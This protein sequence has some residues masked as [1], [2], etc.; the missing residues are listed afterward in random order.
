MIRFYTLQKLYP[1]V[2]TL[3]GDVAYDE[4]DNVVEYDPTLIDAEIAKT[5]YRRHRAAE[6]PTIGDQLD[7][8]FHAGIFPA[9]MA[10]QI[11]AIKDR[12]PKPE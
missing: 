7:A 8:L 6:Y 3:R 2:V 10:A 11:Q 12:Y 9:E 5:E 1:Q 4:Q